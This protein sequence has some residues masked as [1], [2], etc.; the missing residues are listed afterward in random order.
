MDAESPLRVLIVT[1]AFPAPSEAFAG[2]EVRALRSLGVNVS[3][4]ALRPAHRMA[5]ELLTDWKLDSLD[6][7]HG[8]AAGLARG[9]L[10]ALRHPIV[11]VVTVAWLVRNS[12]RQPAQLLSSLLLLPSCIG[13]YEE[14]RRR[15][16]DVI[17]LFWGHYPAVVGYLALRWLPRTH[18]SVS[19]GAYDMLMRFGPS[20]DV[21]RRAHSLSTQAACNA[22]TLASLGIPTQSLRVLKRGVDLESIPAD[23]QK[24]PDAPIV[25]IARLEENKGVDDVL[26]AFAAIY[27]RHPRVTL[28]I[29]GEGPCRRTL[30]QLAASLGVDD[31]VRFHGALGHSA[32]IELL[33][34][35][36]VMMLMSRNPSERLPNAVKEAMA[37]RCLCV[38]TRTPGIDEL[39]P[40]PAVLRIVGRGDWRAASRHLDEILGQQTRHDA[41]RDLAREFIFARLDARAVARERVAIWTTRRPAQCAG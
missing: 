36:G 34:K 37:C 28:E 16:P 8:G 1:M 11:S 10:A 29:I 27:D 9:V 12:W 21:A 38:V 23:C 3:V 13:I 24:R 20:I 6:L 19:L 18:V 22:D 14:C 26:R 32:V 31:R 5:A 33:R 30:E 39:S 35:A 41:E 2:V 7:I 15:A 25:T 40:S 17:H 4:R